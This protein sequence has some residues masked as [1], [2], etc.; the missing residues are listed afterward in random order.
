MEQLAVDTNAVIEW[1]RPEKPDPPPIR[2]ARSIVVPLPVLGELYT[3]AFSSVRRDTN[4][5][6]LVKLTRENLLIAPDE[7]TA[8]IYG[9]LRARLRFDKIGASKINDVW[10]A[11][12]AIQH[13]LPLLTN[14]RG[15]DIFPELRTI[16]W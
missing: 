11:A 9:Q 2:G 3:G 5:E 14:D 1:L 15:F 16:H 8:S 12:L 13:S 4:I 7:A 6:L 10:I